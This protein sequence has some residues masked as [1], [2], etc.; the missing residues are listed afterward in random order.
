MTTEQQQAALTSAGE[1]TVEPETAPEAEAVEGRGKPSLDGKFAWQSCIAL[2]RIQKALGRDGAYGL[3]VYVT[4]CRLSSQQKNASK[5]KAPIIAVASMA[6]MSYRKAW[7]ILYL[8]QDEAKVIQVI[9]SPREKGKLH[10]EPHEYVL[11]RFKTKSSNRHDMQSDNRHSVQQAIGTENKNSVQRSFKTL[12]KV[13][14]LKQGSAKESA[15]P[16][17]LASQGSAADS[18]AS[19]PDRN[20][21]SWE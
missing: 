10:Y 5:V 9:K 14:S 1:I 8:L 13:E 21:N 20:I 3:A 19:S 17:S 15:S 4:L 7:E 18:D 12:P 6:C 2:D 16:C 11:V